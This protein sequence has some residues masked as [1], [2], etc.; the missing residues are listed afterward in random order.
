MESTQQ[1]YKVIITSWNVR[2]M[3]KLV[4][5]KKILDRIKLLKSK[6]VFI[7]ESHLTT[8]DIQIITKRWPGQVFH[9]CFTSHARGVLILIHKSIPFQ[10][11]KVI[12]DPGG[13]YI[14]LQGTVLSQKINLITVYG[15]NDDSPSFFENLFLTLSVLDGTYIIGGDFNCTLDPVLDRSSQNDSTHTKTRKILHNYMQDLKLHD[16]WRTKNPT[17]IQYSCFSG[18]CKSHSRIDY[19]LTS[20]DLEPHVKDC[21]YNSIVLSDHAPV[22]VEVQL[23]R[24][25]HSPKRW[26]LQTFLLRD[27]VFTKFVGKCI[28]NYFDLNKDETSASIRWEAF[29]AYI[30]GEI[31]SFTG[32]LNRKQKAETLS[33]EEQIK[34]LENE[35]YSTKDPQK[36]QNLRIMRAKYDKLTTDKVAKSLMWTKQAYYDQGEKA[37]KLLAWR[38]KKMQ[39]DRAILNIELNSGV[40]TTDPSEINERFREFYEQ[41]YKSECNVNEAVQNNFLDKL[42]FQKLTEED[43]EM[44]DR[45]LTVTDII[46]AIGNLNSGKAPGQDGLPVEFYKVFKNKLAQP[47]LDMFK[48]SYGIGNLPDSLRLATIT[49]IL[50]HDK[51]Q[52]DCAS[53][54]GISLMGCDMKILCKILSKRIENHVP[55]LILNDQQGFVQQRQGYHNIRRVLNILHEKHNTRDTAMLAVD[56]CQAFDRIEWNYLLK[57][58]PRYGLGEK[59]IKWVQL[60][61]TNPT[62]Q[63]LTNN[64]ISRPFNLQRSTR[65]GCPLSPILFT[66]AM[67]PLAIAVRTQT[68][69][70]GLEIGGRKHV[71]S[72]F[73]DDIIFFLT[74]L[75]KHHSQSVERT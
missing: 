37:S 22:S 73:A 30:R 51:P 44:I 50:K 52:T 71:I 31:I 6:I 28:D 12:T 66:L 36:L 69:L 10:K 42:Q 13:R 57:L 3:I 19:F 41:L 21:W 33:M 34:T 53:Y 23:G 25:K 38:I 54:R 4:K 61:Y 74:D 67:E 72:L 27:E 18:S 48:E 15:P 55:K 32:T 49:L 14:I 62:A 5:A 43:K 11:S 9:A 40:L 75:K 59:F 35:F 47:L 8:S 58:L 20:I 56:A 17:N 2:G 16:V 64:N 39:S 24:F 60:L 70:S 1:N 7:Q 46:E 26:R 45:P 63:V 29:K 68:G 65:Q